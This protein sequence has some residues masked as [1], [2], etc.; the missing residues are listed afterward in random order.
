M[1]YPIRPSMAYVPFGAVMAQLKAHPGMAADAGTTSSGIIAPDSSGA[2]GTSVSGVAGTSFAGS[3]VMKPYSW[4]QAAVKSGMG[5]G[6]YFTDGNQLYKQDSEKTYQVTGNADGD[7]ELPPGELVRTVSQNN[8]DQTDS[9]PKAASSGDGGLM[10]NPEQ[11]NSPPRYDHIEDRK[12]TDNERAALKAVGFN[13]DE[14]DQI[15]LHIVKGHPLMPKKMDGLTTDKDNIYFRDGKYDPNTPDG[16]AL[17]AHEVQHT[18]Q[19]RNGMTYV[20]YL[21][22]SLLGYRNNKYEKEAYERQ[23]EAQQILEGK[24]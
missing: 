2:P 16:L 7:R 18:Q 24:P 5:S 19:Y 10:S 4:Q 3:S 6:G 9:S 17:L 22:N 23:K 15:S 21:G 20:G 12:L 14:I 13:D 11:D 1:P 8:K